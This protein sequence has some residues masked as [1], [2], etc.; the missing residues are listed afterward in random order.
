MLLVWQQVEFDKWIRGAGKVLSRQILALQDFNGEGGVLKTVSNT[1]L[2]STQLLTHCTFM[3]I[4]LWT[5]RQLGHTGKRGH[6]CYYFMPLLLIYMVQLYCNR[7]IHSGYSCINSLVQQDMI[8]W[9]IAW[10]SLCAVCTVHVGHRVF[11]IYTL[12]PPYNKHISETFYTNTKYISL[13]I[14]LFIFR[15]YSLF[16]YEPVKLSIESC[17]LRCCFNCILHFN[18]LYTV[19]KHSNNGARII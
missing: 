15:I 7:S 18:A 5:G 17:S 10:C 3:F 9:H 14:R 4:F 13:E 11:S 16:H 6:K 1:E 2:N 19:L 8:F 12:I